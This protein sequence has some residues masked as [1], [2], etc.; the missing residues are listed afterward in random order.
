MLKQ[1]EVQVVINWKCQIC[2]FPFLQA[3]A[4]ELGSTLAVKYHQ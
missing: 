2:F 3:K 4:N 1:V